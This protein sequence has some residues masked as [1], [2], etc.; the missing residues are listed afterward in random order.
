MFVIVI[1]HCHV[2]G[3]VYANKNCVKCG[4]LTFLM[5]KLFAEH[6]FCIVYNSHK[7]FQAYV[8]L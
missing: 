2:G 4:N 6:A 7:S 5:P 1:T 8:C 3:I